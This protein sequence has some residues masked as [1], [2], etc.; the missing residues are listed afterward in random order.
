MNALQIVRNLSTP[1]TVVAEFNAI[2]AAG[3]RVSANLTIVVNPTAS[4]YLSASQNITDVGL[5]VNFSVAANGGTSP[6]AYS[7][8]FGDGGAS[9]EIATAHTYSEA[10]LFNVQSWANDSV[11][12][13][14]Y[15]ALEVQVNPALAANT[16]RKHVS[17]C[18]RCPGCILPRGSGRHQPRH[19]LVVIRGRLLERLPE[20]DT[21]LFGSWPAH[22]DPD[23]ER[24]GRR[25]ECRAPRYRRGRA[26]SANTTNP[27]NSA[28]NSGFS[29]TELVAATAIGGLVGVL[30]GVV[31]GRIRLPSGSTRSASI[32]GGVN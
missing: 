7:W 18:P 22:R 10:G 16:F 30:V 3:W 23:R 27:P 1:G 24:F 14:S 13:S 26:L 5:P 28:M 31:L 2:D 21:C 17:T 19:F 12:S 4:V 32:E 8:L 20:P 15:D 9:Q 25:H 29:E 6:L 11:G